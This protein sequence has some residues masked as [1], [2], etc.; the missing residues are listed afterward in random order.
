M[1]KGLISICI[2]V[3]GAFGCQGGGDVKDAGTDGPCGVGGMLQEWC[4]DGLH[5][6]IYINADC[7]EESGEVYCYIG[8]DA[9]G[10]GCVPMP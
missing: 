8:C 7:S 4:T 3:C 5:Q 2:I 9:A 6:W 10:V 1:R